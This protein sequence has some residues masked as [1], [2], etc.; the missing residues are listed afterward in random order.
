MSELAYA[1]NWD[2][3][4]SKQEKALMKIKGQTALAH[5]SAVRGD[6][7]PAH[8]IAKWLH[9]LDEVAFK[10]IFMGDPEI[11]WC[12]GQPVPPSHIK[13]DPQEGIKSAIKPR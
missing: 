9:K 10:E 6:C 2:L 3:G 12:L 5:K 8:R 1:G 13:P 11:V 7:G 4:M